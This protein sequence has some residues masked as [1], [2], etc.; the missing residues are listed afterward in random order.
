MTSSSFIHQVLAACRL[1]LV[2]RRINLTKTEAKRARCRKGCFKIWHAPDD[3]PDGSDIESLPAVVRANGV[4]ALLIDT[5]QLYAELGAMQ[6]GMPYIH[7][8]AALHRDYSG[9]TP[10]HF[11]DWPHE[12]T[13]AALARN[14]EA[15]QSLLKCWRAPT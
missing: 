6:M 15:S 8:S 2:L 10:P 5:V 13:P 3:G 11:S 12:T 9:Y 7:V 14:R 1:F 4:D